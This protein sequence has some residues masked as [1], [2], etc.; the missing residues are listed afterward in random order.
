MLGKFRFFHTS[1][2]P[3][4]I[5]LFVYQCT[6]IHWNLISRHNNILSQTC[7]CSTPP[8]PLLTLLHSCTCSFTCSSFH[9]CWVLEKGKRRLNVIWNVLN[10][11]FLRKLKLTGG[12]VSIQWAQWPPSTSPLSAQPQTE[13]QCGIRPACFHPHLVVLGL[14]TSLLELYNSATCADGCILP[15]AWLPSPYPEFFF[16]SSLLLI[17]FPLAFLQRCKY[18]T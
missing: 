6:G 18:E 13:P 3:D 15:R 16:L 14:C 1:Q 10:L 7:H 5:K 17:S 11:V 8:P 9:L 12:K 2:H 4:C